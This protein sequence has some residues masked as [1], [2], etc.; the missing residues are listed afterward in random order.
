MGQQLILPLEGAEPEGDSTLPTRL[1]LPVASEG[2][3]P[4]DD[5]NR[6][7]EPWWPGAHA[8][9]RRSGDRL[10]IRT[11]HLSDPLAAFPELRGLVGQL[12]A[13]GLIVEGTLLALD[14]DGRPDVG[15]L[16]RRLSSSSRADDR[17]EGAFVASDLLYLDGRSL[18]RQPFEERRERLAEV[19]PD[20][21]R[22]VLSRGLVGEGVTRGHAVAALGI[23]AISARRLDARWRQGPAG[24]AWLHI[25]VSDEPATPTRP[26][27]V[28]LEKL[29][30][31]E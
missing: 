7:F 9:L 13:D 14:A 30:L 29:P 26:F 19:L 10:E 22:C 23:D 11:E 6:F 8:L 24:D 16:R 4:F 20:S 21:D 15:L 2:G 17:A 1:A 12:A 18:V 28:L 27:L 3:V 5:T 31:G 25:P